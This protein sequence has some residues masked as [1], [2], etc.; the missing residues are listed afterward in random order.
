MFQIVACAVTVFLSF[1][2]HVQLVMTKWAE[3]RCSRITLETVCTEGCQ[4]YQQLSDDVELA[5]RGLLGSAALVK[6]LPVGRGGEDGAV[7]AAASVRLLGDVCLPVLEAHAGARLVHP[8]TIRHHVVDAQPDVFLQ[9]QTLAHIAV[10][11]VVLISCQRGAQAASFGDAVFTGC[12][13]G[14]LHWVG[15]ETLAQ[16]LGAFQTNYGAK[17]ED[18]RQYVCFCSP[19]PN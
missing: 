5:H 2:W 6:P 12:M 17:W 18:S 3:E 7:L 9:A 10:Q 14:L 13:K 15:Q 11:L 1:L 19:S 8:L 16:D 4:I